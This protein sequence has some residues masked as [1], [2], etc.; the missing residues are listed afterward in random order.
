MAWGVGGTAHV[1]VWWGDLMTGVEHASEQGYL[2]FRKLVNAAD[3]FPT[4]VKRDLL[5]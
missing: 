1:G 4:G 2:G 3:E 5:P